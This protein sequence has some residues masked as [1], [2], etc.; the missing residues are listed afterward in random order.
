MKGL[1]DS[2]LSLRK[3]QK[4]IEAYLKN[5]GE[6]LGRILEET[7]NTTSSASKQS[8][9]EQ[10]AGRQYRKR[11]S[12]TLYNYNN[13][14]LWAGEVRLGTPPQD[15]TIL[16]DTGELSVFLTK[17]SSLTPLIYCAGSSDF[18]VPS[19]DPQCTGCTGN[20]FDSGLSTTS[21][22]KN[23]RFASKSLPF[24]NQF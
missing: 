2:P 3:Y 23:G 4:T 14:L 16:F 24:L 8:S 17:V 5:T 15:F 1:F 19:N 13:D 10:V 22:R 12:E 7:N 20:K 21:S 6:A 18:W 9:T 11:Q